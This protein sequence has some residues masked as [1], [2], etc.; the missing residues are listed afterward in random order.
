MYLIINV[1]R[2]SWLISILQLELVNEEALKLLPLLDLHQ[3]LSP[4]ICHTRLLRHR[5]IFA[6]FKF[7]C[8]SY[9]L[10]LNL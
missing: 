2:D 6:Y 9:Y 5:E 4:N 7:D 1:F 8:L 3:A 10:Y